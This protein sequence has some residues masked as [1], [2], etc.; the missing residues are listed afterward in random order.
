MW[1]ISVSDIGACAAASGFVPATYRP[2]DPQAV[3]DAAD[4]LLGAVVRGPHQV[5]LT[6][7]GKDFHQEVVPL[8]ILDL[9]AEGDQQVLRRLLVG[10]E[11]QA[12]RPVELA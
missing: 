2:V 8:A 4:A 6:E 3:V 10:R 12:A 7:Q 5:D 11:D 1:S 9:L